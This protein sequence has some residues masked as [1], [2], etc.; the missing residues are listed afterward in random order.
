MLYKRAIEELL[1]NELLNTH[2]SIMLVGPRSIGKT[3]ALTQLAKSTL[4]L[5]I[6][7]IKEAVEADPDLILS[8][9][10]KP[11]LVDEWQELPEILWAIKRAIDT[12]S[13][14]K[15]GQYLIAGSAEANINTASYPLSGRTI[16]KNL[17]GLTQAELEGNPTHNIID[18]LFSDLTT[19]RFPS[20]K[21]GKQDLIKRIARGRFPNLVGLKPKTR[22]QRL[23]AYI[24]HTIQRDA[25]LLA[26]KRPRP[27]L[28]KSFL[29][30]VASFTGEQPTKKMLADRTNISIP[31][32]DT[33]LDTMHKL[34]LIATLPGWK[35]NLTK[36]ELDNK[37]IH[38][39]DT[40]L[41]CNL[42]NLSEESLITNDRLGHL[43]E[44]FVVS[45]FLTHLQTSQ[46][47]AQLFHF[48][49]KDQT[50]VDLV[51][52]TNEGQIAAIE[53]K[54]GKSVTDQDAKGI[55]H[56]KTRLKNRFHCGIIV[57]TIEY[58]RQVEDR[59]WAVPLSYLW[60][61]APQT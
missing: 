48:R 49:T 32:A 43:T 26:D 31:T 6:P 50:E 44:T 11:V 30:V 61:T 25:A 35:S 52:E 3:T 9:T 5:S 19:S 22:N 8:R 24:D 18:E 45:E 29:K 1:K 47:Q 56:L 17:Y 57:S 16:R 34:C 20:H 40:S 28:F 46:T 58:P 36:R 39:I 54:A 10:E 59:I 53:I 12:D 23:N 27:E 38:L 2:P 55:R 14:N 41:A 7:S 51:A 33:Y 60:Q 4:D 13:Q 21:G 42:T 15:P 37:K